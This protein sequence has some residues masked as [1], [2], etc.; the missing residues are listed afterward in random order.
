MLTRE[1]A[2]RLVAD[3]ISAVGADIGEGDE[4][5]ILEESTIERQWGWVVFYTSR[6]WLE[7][8]DLRFALAGNAPFLVERST[9][10]VLELG[11][12]QSVEQYIAAYER[13][14]D[15]HGK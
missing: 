1:G 2:H 8:Q 15:P 5:V 7:T 11:T 10:L 3:R 12:S 14:G 13:T 6:L 4:L 9:G